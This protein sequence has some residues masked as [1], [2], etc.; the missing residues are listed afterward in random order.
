MSDATTNKTTTKDSPQS[1]QALAYRQAVSIAQEQRDLLTAQGD[2]EGAAKITGL[3]YDLA[4]LDRDPVQG[5]T[6]DPVAVGYTSESE[7]A[8]VALAR[9]ASR[10]GYRFD[11]TRRAWIRFTFTTTGM[12]VWEVVPGKAADV[13]RTLAVSIAANLA[14]GDPK[15][16]KG[17]KEKLRADLRTRYGTN[18]GVSALAQLMLSWAGKESS[19]VY[20]TS[21]ALEAVD[22]DDHLW[23]A[24]RAFDLNAAGRVSL[25]AHEASTLTPHL[26]TAAVAPRF[27]D[28]LPL[29]DNL[30]DAIFEDDE[31]AYEL[32]MALLGLA[33]TGHSNRV[34]GVFWGDSGTGKT[35]LLRLVSELLGDY[36]H[37]ANAAILDA[38]G[39]GNFVHALQGRRLVWVDEG[40]REGHYAAEHLKALTGGSRR[41]SRDLYQA[42]VTW[43]PR[44]TLFFAANHAP[45]VAD[46]ALRARVRSVHFQGDPARVDRAVK[47]IYHNRAAWEQEQPGVLAW[48]M[49]KAGQYLADPTTVDNPEGIAAELDDLAREQDPITMWVEERCTPTGETNSTDLYEDFVNFCKRLGLKGWPG[50]VAWGRRLNELGYAARKSHGKKVRPLSPNGIAA[51]FICPPTIP[52]RDPLADGSGSAG[53]ASGIV[54]DSSGTVGEGHC[55]PV[56]GLVKHPS[57]TLGDSGD[58]NYPNSDVEV[59]NKGK[60]GNIEKVG[61]VT[62]PPIPAVPGTYADGTPFYRREVIDGAERWVPNP[63]P[64][65]GTTD[66]ARRSA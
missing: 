55:P 29:W 22:R 12:P 11:A 25:W 31:E 10:L 64:D 51:G 5:T 13:T 40:P 21:E 27:T 43:T 16:D 44:F 62:V 17:T 8:R 58:S 18:A 23:V 59:E 9:V 37:E 46:P 66:D 30:M 3:A 42:A 49:L 41:T 50:N 24:G 52:S 1:F 7:V 38:R 63:A 57:V 45:Q 32:T 33:L 34:L 53:G 39:D 56:N 4:A 36:A 65:G 54:G 15:A 28:E 47:A 14:A 61:A 2:P 48:L 19:F 20:T 35:S 6:F 26:R 60:R